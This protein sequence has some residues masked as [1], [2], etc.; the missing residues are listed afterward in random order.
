MKKNMDNE[1]LVCEVSEG[2]KAVHEHIYCGSKTFN[3][4]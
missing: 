3:A 1:I 2:A 4:I